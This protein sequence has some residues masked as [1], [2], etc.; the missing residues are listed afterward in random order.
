MIAADCANAM[1]EFNAAKRLISEKRQIHASTLANPEIDI[2][3]MVGPL[4]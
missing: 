4:T 3:S 2:R 1:L